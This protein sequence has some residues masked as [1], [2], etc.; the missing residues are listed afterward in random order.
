[1]ETTYHEQKRDF[2]MSSPLPCVLQ[3]DWDRGR[4]KYLWLAEIK[5]M[6]L[7]GPKAAGPV[8]FTAQP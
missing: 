5:L 7:G 4:S 2:R 8:G 3:L 1:M 6:L